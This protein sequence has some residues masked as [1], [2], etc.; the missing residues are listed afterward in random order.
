[1]S[2]TISTDGIDLD[3]LLNNAVDLTEQKIVYANNI[4]LRV[5]RDDVTLDLYHLAP[6]PTNPDEAAQAY[7]LSRVVLPVGLARI[8]AGSLQDAVLDS[9]DASSTDLRALDMLFAR[10]DASDD[11]FNTLDDD[12]LRDLRRDTRL[13]SLYATDEGQ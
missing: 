12:W 7:R 5:M 8:L 10:L 11:D 9:E 13:D 2:E 3:E 6:N 1:M 4:R